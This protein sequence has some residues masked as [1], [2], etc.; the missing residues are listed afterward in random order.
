MTDYIRLGSD[1]S[2]GDDIMFQGACTDAQNGNYANAHSTFLFLAEKRYS[3]AAYNLGIMFE[4]GH[5]V[6]PN[7][8]HAYKWFN[9]AEK[10]LCE[11]ATKK[12]V[13]LKDSM[14]NKELFDAEDLID[15]FFNNN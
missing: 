4:L 5:H 1:S 7:K 6:E 13:A 14:T 8:V 2:S 11:V 15:K 10:L 12:R 9:I 3:G